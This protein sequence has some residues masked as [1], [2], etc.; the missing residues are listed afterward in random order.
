MYNAILFISIR[1]FLI[2][3]I[4]PLM[5]SDISGQTVY[6]KARIETN[7]GSMTLVLYKETPLHS[8]NFIDLIQKGLYD[9]VIFHRIINNFMIQS[10][11]LSTRYDPIKQAQGTRDITYTIPAEFYPALY[12]KKGAIAAARQGDNVNPTRA[13]SGSQFYIVQ[14]TKFTKDQLDQL[15]QKQMHIKFTPE[16]RKIYT[17]VGGTPHLDYAYTVFGQVIEGL[18]VIDKIASVPTDQKD[19]PIEDIRIIKIRIIE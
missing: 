4:L 1:R 12:H 14:G 13:S 9:G 16:Q 17:E 6:K 5:F 18:D 11:D 7:M 8:D 15:E 3:L 19:R 2:L 10:G